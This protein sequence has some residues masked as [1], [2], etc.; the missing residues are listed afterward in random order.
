MAKARGKRGKRSAKAPHYLA[1]KT[2]T[3][4]RPCGWGKAP[5]IEQA[6]QIADAQYARHGHPEGAGC[7]PGEQSSGCYQV[8][9]VDA[10]PVDQPERKLHVVTDEH[11]GTVTARA[12]VTEFVP[13]S[14]LRSQSPAQLA[15]DVNA[16]FGGGRFIVHPDDLQRVRSMV[17]LG[18]T[19]RYRPTDL[20]ARL[21]VEQTIAPLPW[22]VQ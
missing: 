1:I 7:Y 16:N 19:I 10:T 20:H 8:H 11:E 15:Y 6:K 14:G 21:V 12:V 4:G 2:N 5:T 3:D 17:G 22:E 9:L 18:V 13:S